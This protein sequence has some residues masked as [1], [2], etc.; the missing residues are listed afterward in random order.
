MSDRDQ[1]PESE[2]EYHLRR[3]KEVILA[4]YEE[5]KR[6]GV[7]PEGFFMWR[8][9]DAVRFAQAIVQRAREVK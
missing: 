2:A 8:E 7:M 6:L 5:L 1:A 3:N 9:Q 4:F